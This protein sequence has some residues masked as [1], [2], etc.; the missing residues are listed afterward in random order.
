M[1]ALNWSTVG[2]YGGLNSSPLSPHR[3]RGDDQEGSR[4]LAEKGTMDAARLPRGVPGLPACR[5][6]IHTYICTYIY[7]YLY[8]YMYVYIH[9]IFIDTFIHLYVFI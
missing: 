2:P 6:Y 4:G 8:I 7:R 9:E 1:R 5:S 3:D